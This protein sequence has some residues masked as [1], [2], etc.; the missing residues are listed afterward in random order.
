MDVALLTL[1]N[2]KVP[3]LVQEIHKLG[4]LTLKGVSGEEKN[5]RFELNFYVKFLF[6]KKSF[7]N[8]TNFSSHGISG[9]LHVP[10]VSPA[11]DSFAMISMNVSGMY[12]LTS[13]SRIFQFFI[14]THFFDN[15]FQL[16][17]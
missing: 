4:V 8:F 16:W 15:F 13:I 10:L 12:K 7:F 2:V 17:Q 9:V 14:F 6:Y 1:M 11:M 3:I 5:N